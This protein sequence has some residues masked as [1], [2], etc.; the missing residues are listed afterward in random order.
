M[1]VFCVFAFLF[2]A[3]I[4]ADPRLEV[5][6]GG[7]GFAHFPADFANQDNEVF[8]TA[9]VIEVTSID[10]VASGDT[11]WVTIKSAGAIPFDLD[12]Q[13]RFDQ[14]NTGF[15][16][17]LVDTNGTTYTSNNWRATV[18]TTPLGGQTYEVYYVMH[19]VNAQQQE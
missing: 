15:A 14:N 12:A 16:C 3:V 9:G 6:A 10:G 4:T 13:T 19:C 5:R 17:N 11:R 7:G 2:S 8:S 1:S 18:T